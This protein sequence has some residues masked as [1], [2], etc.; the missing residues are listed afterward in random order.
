MIYYTRTATISQG[1]ARK[2]FELA[3]R[4]ADLVNSKFPGHNVQVLRRI[5]GAMSDL[6]WIATSDS[7][8]QLEQLLADME[9]DPEFQQL[10]AESNSEGLFVTSSV[11][12][13]FFQT[14]P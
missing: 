1:Q 12:S 9:S 3:V 2:A 8:A 11:R 13:A 5:S 14:V 10:D 7:L 4:V 6:S